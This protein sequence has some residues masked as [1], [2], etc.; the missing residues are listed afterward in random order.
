VDLEERFKAAVL[1][2]YAAAGMRLDDFHV[3]SLARVY[4][5]WAEGSDERVVHR[6]ERALAAS[7]GAFKLDPARPSRPSA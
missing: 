6:V 2:A 4:A 3:A 1:R 7:L 5:T